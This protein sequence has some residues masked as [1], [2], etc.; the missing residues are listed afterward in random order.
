MPFISSLDTWSVLLSGFRW[1][2]TVMASAAVP[3]RMVSSVFITLVTPHRATLTQQKPALQAYGSLAREK[4]Q[5]AVRVTP[6]DSITDTRQKKESVSESN[7]GADSGGQT[8]T[9]ASAQ[10]SDPQSPTPVQP[11]SNREKLQEG[12]REDAGNHDKK[13]PPLINIKKWWATLLY[14]KIM[15]L[16]PSGPDEPKIARSPAFVERQLQSFYWKLFTNL[17]QGKKMRK[18]I[19]CKNWNLRE[20]LFLYPI[21]SIWL[22]WT[23]WITFA[24][25]SRF[26]SKIRKEK[27]VA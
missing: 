24:E 16:V 5:P 27:N 17:Y 18:T 13:N 3:K 15:N 1:W 23:N 25:N 22:I 14:S 12:S 6:S 11:G 21:F 8:H 4:Q 19:R 26:Y 10:V 7:G 20:T 9:V 2:Q